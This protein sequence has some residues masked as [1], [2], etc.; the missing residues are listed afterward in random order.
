MALLEVAAYVGG[1]LA[2]GLGMYFGIGGFFEWRYYR[3]R[4]QA[5]DW[6]CQPARWP[7]PQARRREIA[8]GTSNMVLASIVSGLI[9]YHFVQHGGTALFWSLDQHGLGYVVASTLVYLLAT[10]L[11]LYWAH[12]GLHTPRLYRLIHRVHHRWGSPTAFTATAMHPLELALYQ[13]VML[14]PLF[15]VPLHVVGVVFVLIA[16]NFYALVDHSGVRQSSI[17]PFIAPSQF[18]DDHHAHISVNFGQ[19]FAWWDRLFGTARE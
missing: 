15:V 12:R 1:A 10:D 6:K 17:W 3:R 9:A 11:L 5:A 2:G 13:S 4:A 19:S 7:S 8:L 18:H 14:V 16:T